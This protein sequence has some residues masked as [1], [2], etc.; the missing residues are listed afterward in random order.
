MPL[1]IRSKLTRTRISQ[2]TIFPSDESLKKWKASLGISDEII[3]SDPSD[4][5]KARHLSTPLLDLLTPLQVIVE[6]LA[7]EVAGRPDVILDVI[8]SVNAIC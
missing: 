3:L 6:Q 1:S 4:P 2:L 5:R 8:L 7:L